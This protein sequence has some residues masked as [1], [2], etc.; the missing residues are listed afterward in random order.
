MPWAFNKVGHRILTVRFTY[1]KGVVRIF[2]AGHWR[3]GRAIYGKE[4]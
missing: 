4:K 3:K 2:G 1:R